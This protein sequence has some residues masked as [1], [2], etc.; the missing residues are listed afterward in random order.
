MND[1]PDIDIEPRRPNLKALRQSVQ[2]DEVERHAR[3]LGADWLGEGKQPLASLRVEIPKYVDKL[4]AVAAAERG[5]TKQ[6]LILE[7]LQAK[8]YPV[9]DSDLIE[10]KR[11]VKRR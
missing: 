4:L 8:G 1:L 9:D 7:A 6:Y 5:V 2:D 3:K 10:D 11:K